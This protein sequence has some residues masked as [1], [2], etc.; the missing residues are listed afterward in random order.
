MTF[1]IKLAI[2]TILLLQIA[3]TN[4]QCGIRWRGG[5]RRK[6]GKRAQKDM[7][8]SEIDSNY[9]DLKIETNEV[10]I[11]RRKLCEDF[12]KLIDFDINA[13]SEVYK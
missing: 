9:T 1:K 6:R 5:C 10:K 12:L 2:I 8:D 4:S 3:F 13:I 7:W 11:S